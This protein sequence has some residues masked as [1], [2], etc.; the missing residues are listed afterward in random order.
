M[1]S[2]PNVFIIS[3]AGETHIDATELET[4]C[5]ALLRELSNA[6]SWHGF[7][8]LCFCLSSTSS[9]IPTDRGLV[10]C[11]E[12]PDSVAAHGCEAAGGAGGRVIIKV[13]SRVDSGAEDQNSSCIRLNKI[14]LPI[15]ECV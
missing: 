12:S 9:K 15:E 2:G 6:G 10:G 14:E 11:G 1:Y 13:D 3:L 8:A 7:E 5:N 4:P